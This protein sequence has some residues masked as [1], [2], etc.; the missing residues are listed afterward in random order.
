MLGHFCQVS[1]SV[2]FYGPPDA[3]PPEWMNAMLH[4]KYIIE[5]DKTLQEFPLVFVLYSIIYRQRAETVICHVCVMQD[6][7]NTESFS[8]CTVNEAF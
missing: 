3:H 6:S 2:L 8:R 7:E 1:L 4:I 5:G